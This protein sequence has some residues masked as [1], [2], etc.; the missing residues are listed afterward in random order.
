MKFN[1]LRPRGYFIYCRFNIKKFYMMLTLHLCIVYEFQKNTANFPHA[2]LNEWFCI[3]E[4]ESV[5]CAVRAKFLC[6]TEAFRL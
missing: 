2:T 5:Y 1:L 3:T 4:V 6:K